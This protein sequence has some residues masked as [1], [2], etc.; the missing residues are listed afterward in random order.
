MFRS[1]GD[2]EDQCDARV[3]QHVLDAVDPIVAAA[4]RNQQC[5]AAV[6]DLDE[7]RLVALGRAVEPWLLPV[8]RVGNGE[9]AMKARPIASTC[10][11]S[12]LRA[13]VSTM[14]AAGIVD[15]TWSSRPSWPSRLRGGSPIGVPRTFLHRTA[16][17]PTAGG[18]HP[19]LS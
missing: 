18:Y 5:A 12:F 10:S 13:I 19:F 1:P 4:V 16:A 3:L 15:L 8:A 9:A 14:S 6:L 2:Q 7:A 17:P 11:I